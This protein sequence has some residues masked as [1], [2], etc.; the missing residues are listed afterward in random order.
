M[1]TLYCDVGLR[2]RLLA[3]ATASLATVAADSPCQAPICPDPS[4]M[5]T[6]RAATLADPT[7]DSRSSGLPGTASAAQEDLK[8]R[9]AVLPLGKWTRSHYPIWMWSTFSP[10]SK[11]LAVPFVDGTVL[12][13]ET[14]KGAPSR[15][16]LVGGPRALCEAYAPTTFCFHLLAFSPDGRSLV[17]SGRKEVVVWELESGEVAFRCEKE[18]AEYKVAISP[19]GRLL[20]VETKN[21]MRLWELGAGETRTSSMTGN[22]RGFSPDGRL[23]ATVVDHQVLLWD[24][25]TRSASGPPLGH[26]HD[27]G[28]VVFSPDGRSLATMTYSG[29]GK[30]LPGP[31]HNCWNV[32]DLASRELVMTLPCTYGRT[33]AA[34]FSPDSRLLAATDEREPVTVWDVGTRRLLATLE[35]DKK[36]GEGDLDYRLEGRLLVK[37]ER[38]WAPFDRG[39]SPYPPDGRTVV[40]VIKGGFALWDVPSRK[41][42]GPE[43]H[44]KVADR[45]LELSPDGRLLATT[46]KDNLYLWDVA[47]IR[48]AE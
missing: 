32:W 37:G 39:S 19:T 17:W 27:V 48:A 18:K 33:P 46:D 26:G 25:E 6:D 1:L 43:V 30:I 11:L 24:V 35:R 5:V 21:A 40:H 10:D 28:W 45:W 29:F 2:L 3:V 4:V 14:D 16:A 23:L 42:V 15:P 36:A 31:T 12:L 44:T 13:F 20:A 34:G 41:Q 8:F 38:A 47:R 9:R 7:Q 22:L